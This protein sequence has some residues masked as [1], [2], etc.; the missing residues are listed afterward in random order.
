[1][2]ANYTH[3]LYIL[4]RSGSMSS[5]AKDV[6][7]GFNNFIKTQKELPGECTLSLIQFDNEYRV[8]YNF[9]PIVNVA[10]LEFMP[11]GST[12]LY[13]AI[14][15]AIIDTGNTL[16]NSPVFMRP[17]K[18]LV[19]VHTDGEKNSSKEYS[20]AKIGEMI[21]HQEEKYNW[22][23]SFIGTNFD[24]MGEGSDLGFRRGNTKAYDNN[25]QGINVMYASLS[26]AVRSC[27]SASVN[28]YATMDMF[29][30]DDKTETQT[31]P[32]P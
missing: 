24:V 21:K 23:F 31:T 22:K 32:Q 13:D 1:M 16:S 8:N 7:S 3:I 18:I 17:E 6:T 9:V 15:R 20:K 30:T 10:N 26:N 2:K 19:I 25:S 14:G 12:A 29:T 4:D 11:R 27:R 5:V 28:S